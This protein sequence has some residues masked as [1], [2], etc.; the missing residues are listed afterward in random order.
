MKVKNAY[1]PPVGLSK[2]SI[3]FGLVLGFTIILLASDLD[4]ILDIK[5]NIN[6]KVLFSVVG[7]LILIWSIYNDY[8]GANKTISKYK[9]GLFNSFICPQCH[10]KIKKPLEHEKTNPAA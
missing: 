4:L 6:W 9:I 2:F 3:I 8:K 10:T 5:I 1:Y 7:I